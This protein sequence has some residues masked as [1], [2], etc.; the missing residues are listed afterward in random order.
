MHNTAGRWYHRP[1]NW[2]RD[3]RLAYVLVN[4]CS[5]FWASNFALGRL[6]RDDSRPFTLTAARFTVA[7]VVYTAL[8]LRRPTARPAMAAAI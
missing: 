3:P 1:M 4:L 7:G 8:L 5:L 6:L 2:R